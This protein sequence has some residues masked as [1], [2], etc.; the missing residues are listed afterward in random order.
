MS[1]DTIQAA[2]NQLKAG[3]AIRRQA[4]ETLEKELLN[5]PKTKKGLSP[6][7]KQKIL[8]RFFKNHVNQ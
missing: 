4:L 6:E 8:A 3:E 1:K 5:E 2:L 7:H